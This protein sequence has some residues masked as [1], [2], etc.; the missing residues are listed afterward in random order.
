MRY[1]AAMTIYIYLYGIYS[2]II[3]VVRER[4]KGCAELESQG[5]TGAICH[6]LGSQCLRK[7]SKHTI[8]VSRPRLKYIFAY[9]KCIYLYNV[10]W[11]ISGNDCKTDQGRTARRMGEN[12]NQNIAGSRR[13][14]GC[15][16]YRSN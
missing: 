1:K 11:K 13:K 8:N 10:I 14:K 15:T 6:C 5:W 2:S 7:V 3:T 12:Q 16:L 4:R 9:N